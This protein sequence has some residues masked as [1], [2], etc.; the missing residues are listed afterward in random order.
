MLRGFDQCLMHWLLPSWGSQESHQQEA[1]IVQW[2]AWPREPRRTRHRVPAR[3]ERS[4][5]DPSAARE[6]GSLLTSGFPSSVAT[7]VWNW[8]AENWFHF[9]NSPSRRARGRV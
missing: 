6:Q 4:R 3:A 7:K 9:L 8:L 2:A 5:P 1:P